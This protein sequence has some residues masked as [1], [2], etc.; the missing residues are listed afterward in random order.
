MQVLVQLTTTNVHTGKHVE[1]LALF[2][3]A[4]KALEYVVPAPRA[5]CAEGGDADYGKAVAEGRQLQ[6]T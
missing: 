1:A 2:E 5:D 6:G 4:L 3:G